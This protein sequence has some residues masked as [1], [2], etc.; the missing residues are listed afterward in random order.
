[1]A[2]TLAL[3]RKLWVALG[4]I[5]IL[6]GIIGYIIPL[7]PGLVFFILAAFCFAKGS[8]RFLRALLG[9]KVIGPQIMDWKRG[10]GMKL[11]T[12]IIAI[13]TVI[14]SMSFSAFYIVHQ[15]WLKWTILSCALLII[16]IIISMKT[17]KE[18][19]HNG[20]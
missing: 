6:L 12:K 4:F 18:K 15:S 19:P 1:M 14:P 20:K 9:N 5:F 16:V 7:M 2:V 3:Y 11:N 10:R 13:A 8:T 17:K